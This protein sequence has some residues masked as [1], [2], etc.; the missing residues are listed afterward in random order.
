MS[1]TTWTSPGIIDKGWGRS[2]SK[3]REGRMKGSSNGRWSRGRL[4]ALQMAAKSLSVVKAK[5]LQSPM[6]EAR[7]GG[8]KGVKRC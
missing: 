1:Y 4:E 7:G 2:E 6:A 5:K 8:A 3:C